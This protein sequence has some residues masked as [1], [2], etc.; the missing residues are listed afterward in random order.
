MNELRLNLGCGLRKYPGFLNVD[1]Y[2]ECAPDQAVDLEAFPWPWPDDSVAE[3]RMIHVLEH[4]GATTATYLGI[5]RELWRVC[6]HDAEVL[7]VVPHPRHDSFLNDPTHVRPVTGDGLRMFSQTENRRWQAAG[8]ANTPLG[9]YLGI[10]F[11]LRST[12][13]ELDPRWRARLD[14]GEVSREAIFEAMLRE[15]NVVRQATYVLRAIKD[16]VTPR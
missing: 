9:L 13:L 15:N 1:K 16:G 6:R 12:Q 7:I 14:A 2:P 11:E 8:A 3:V 4:L 10:D 5:M